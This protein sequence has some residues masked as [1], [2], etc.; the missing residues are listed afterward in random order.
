[1][2]PDTEGVVALDPRVSCGG[3]HI[4]GTAMGPNLHDLYLAESRNVPPVSRRFP[5]EH[6]RV[7][8]AVAYEERM[9]A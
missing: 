4:V 3:P 2:R 7:R 5:I 1:M 6:R 8:Q 9:A